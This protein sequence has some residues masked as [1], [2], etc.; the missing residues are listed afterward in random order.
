MGTAR[1]DCYKDDFFGGRSFSGTAD[2]NGWKVEDVS[3]AGNPTY[4]CLDGEPT[5]SVQLGMDA[6]SEAQSVALTH[7]D[8]L[9]FDIDSIQRVTYRAKVQNVDAVTTVVLGVAGDHNATIDSIAQNAWFKIEG[10]GSTSSVV[11]ETDD[12]STDNDDVATGQ[13]LANS[14]KEMVIDLSHGKSDVRFY[15]DNGNGQLRRV[16][17]TTTFDMSGYSGS[18]QPYMR[19]A[20]ASGTGTPSVEVDLCEISYKRN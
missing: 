15:I 3:S 1:V 17:S 10:S 2:A 9:S 7:G 6:T 11:V 13:T 18:L 4:A 12:G 5:G 20:K 19:V 8:V 16:A 14:Y